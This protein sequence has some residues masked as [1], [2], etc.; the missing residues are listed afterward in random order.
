MPCVGRPPIWYDK[1]MSVSASAAAASAAMPQPSNV[2]R[3]RLAGSSVKAFAESTRN[4]KTGTI[5]NQFK[6]RFR[7]YIARSAQES[8]DIAPVLGVK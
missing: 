2:I 8:A 1:N 7:R 3:M 6:M 5:T 4:T